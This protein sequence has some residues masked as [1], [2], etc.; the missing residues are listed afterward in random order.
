MAN[1]VKNN[2]LA[3][4]K[5]RYGQVKTLS[6]SFS[7]FQIGDHAARIYVRYSRVHPDRRT[8]YGL[9]REDLTQLEGHPSV[10]VFLWDSQ[11]EPL[12]VAFSEYEELFHSL[13]P[14][15]DGQ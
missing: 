8:F 9:R 14:A 13:Q 12:F 5:S 15:K 1:Q 3:E 11:I 6:G 2:F 4:L 7:L 10:I